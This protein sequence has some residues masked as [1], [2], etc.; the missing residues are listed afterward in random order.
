MKNSVAAQRYL[1]P[2]QQEELW[3]KP[4]DLSR[5][6]ALNLSARSSLQRQLEGVYPEEHP[7]IQMLNDR[8]RNIMAN[9]ERCDLDPRVFVFSAVE[10]EAFV[11]AQGH[12]FISTSMLA[13][14]KN[15]SALDA[16]LFHEA[17]HAIFEDAARSIFVADTIARLGQTRS[18]EASADL[19]A[20][21]EFDEQ[22][23]NPH[24]QMLLLR[25]LAKRSTV[26]YVEGKRHVQEPFDPEHGSLSARQLDHIDLRQVWDLRNYDSHVKD[27]FN[28]RDYLTTP[29]IEILGEV[30]LPS[31]AAGFTDFL[32]Q[33]SALKKLTQADTEACDKL[34]KQGVESL[35]NNFGDCTSSRS[36]ASED[37]RTAIE[38]AFRAVLGWR[39]EGAAPSLA[40]SQLIQVSDLLKDSIGRDLAWLTCESLFSKQLKTLFANAPSSAAVKEELFE[41][42]AAA[43]RTFFSTSPE[44]REQEFERW[45]NS[46][47]L[48]AWFDVKSAVLPV[49]I[50]KHPLA[51]LDVRSFI[52]SDPGTDQLCL[53]SDLVKLYEILGAGELSLEPLVQSYFERSNADA[54]ND[55]EI[56][57]PESL[58]SHLEGRG[59]RFAGLL[60][61]LVQRYM[62]SI[63]N[64]EP[65]EK[66]LLLG[67]ILP[68]SSAYE[69]LKASIFEVD[70]LPEDLGIAP[71]FLLGSAI[72]RDIGKQLSPLITNVVRSKRDNLI[73]IVETLLSSQTSAT[74]SFESQLRLRATLHNLSLAILDQRAIDKESGAESELT[75]REALSTNSIFTRLSQHQE[76]YN[77]AVFGL[78]GAS[79]TREALDV[80]SEYF[81]GPIT[82]TISKIA[83]PHERIEELF[84]LRAKI[85]STS[86][87]LY[88]GGIALVQ[89][90]TDHFQQIDNFAEL[91]KLTALEIII[92]SSQPLAHELDQACQNMRLAFVAV[93]GKRYS[94]LREL[95]L[96]HLLPLISAKDFPSTKQDY[97]LVLHLSLL[98][99]DSH[100]PF[101]LARVAFSKRIDLCDGLAEG[102]MLLQKYSYLPLGV[103]LSGVNQIGDK[104][105]NQTHELS[106][107]IGDAIKIVINGS[108]TQEQTA[109]ASLAEGYGVNAFSADDRLEFL[110]AATQTFRSDEKIR[111]FTLPR[112]FRL[113]SFERYFVNNTNDSALSD[114]REMITAIRQEYHALDRQ[115]HLARPLVPTPDPNRAALTQITRPLP[116]GIAGVTSFRDLLSGLF[117]LDALTLQRLLR[118]VLMEGPAALYKDEDTRRAV[119]ERVVKNYIKLDSSNEQK[120]VQ[121]VSQALQKVVSPEMLY[122]HT[123]RLLTAVA[124]Q[125]PTERTKV[126]PILERFVSENSNIVNI[127]QRNFGGPEAKAKLK[128]ADFNRQVRD[129]LYDPAGGTAELNKLA[130]QLKLVDLA[131]ALRVRAITEL[132]PPT[133]KYHPEGG[134]PYLS[135]TP[136]DSTPEAALSKI[137]K[138]A[139]CL[140]K[141]RRFSDQFTVAELGV[142]LAEYSGALGV[143]LLQLMALYLPLSPEDRATISSVFDKLAGQGKLSAFRILKREA[144]LCED[145]GA[146]FASLEDFGQ[147]IGGASIVTQ[148][149]A[150]VA[151]QEMALGIT[152]PN[153]IER[154][155]SLK[156]L[157]I[158]V[159]DHMIEQEPEN[160][161]FRLVR[162]LIED[163]AEWVI[164]EIE[165]DSYGSQNEEFWRMNDSRSLN[166]HR[167]KSDKNSRWSIRV[168]HSA[169]VNN[170]WVR[171]EEY[172]DSIDLAELQVSQAPTD[173]SAKTINTADARDI[174][175]SIT[176]NY[177]YQVL[178]TGLAHSDIHPGNLALTSKQ[179]IAIF[180]RKFLLKFDQSEIEQL[181]KVL[182]SARKQSIDGLFAAVANIAA[183]QHADKLREILIST[184][185]SANAEQMDTRARIAS[186]LGAMRSVGIK[187]ELK[188]VLLLKN[189]LALEYLSNWAGYSG[190][191]AALTKGGERKLSEVLS[192][193]HRI[194]PKIKITPGLIA[195][196][197]AA[198]K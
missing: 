148:F 98:G 194:V 195:D 86:E 132:N 134:K 25:T 61:P 174:I 41:L 83:D 173:L 187:L 166:E 46:Q 105:A 192:T 57:V 80:L 125:E 159:L 197:V 54:L 66:L 176:E 90:T 183:P 87:R 13:S 3:T 44:G 130:E 140:T 96:T 32:K 43:S 163:A 170:R 49:R 1:T 23:G 68:P 101:P 117:R 15:L 50:E 91:L 149:K 103:L 12:V 127:K 119:L 172:I 102:R 154:T 191:G 77:A 113:N 95:L 141:G 82:N 40:C 145:V 171:A 93:Q 120:V 121:L 161:T 92:Q 129:G 178:T 123:V 156:Q 62:Q 10:Q 139:E 179:E 186:V 151:G 71:I 126:M 185:K 162:S 70:T 153:A 114:I 88:S 26:F 39:D 42:R 17:K 48:L 28:F 55:I 94:E 2:E 146:L 37:S 180:D 56:E 84:K 122:E 14:I 35:L 59:E 124:F 58:M 112:W 155:N 99:Q 110:D 67:A 36:V 131:L 73:D 31:N 8:Y 24:G 22:G 27:D 147:M 81:K 188:W 164:H 158:S 11:L 78:I 52:V 6:A 165:H 21:I 29:L 115:P 72:E 76:A 107:L 19:F 133:V 7:L 169:A 18:F 143:K 150:T 9:F 135:F 85:V 79:S 190:V 38:Q 5:S 160:H 53:G 33:L 144:A 100:L 34:L 137:P 168:P 116:G 136:Q 4:L 69:A 175:T 51:D 63:S 193:A 74:Q 30:K 45:F 184:A 64:R 109:V 111:E 198:S 75:E 196:L 97:E 157:L 106:A 152:N 189:M 20:T 65:L 16:L 104:F 182:L 142:V 108:I 128:F 60:R 118:T 177:L 181:R 167:F 89:L 138:L 47:A